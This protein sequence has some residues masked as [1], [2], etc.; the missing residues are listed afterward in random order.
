MANT[1]L[2]WHPGDVPKTAII[3]PFDL[4]EFLLMPL[5]LKNAAQDLQRLMDGILRNMSIMF[6]YL[7]SI[8]VASK[9]LKDHRNHLC[10]VFQ[11]LS[12]N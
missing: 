9:N 6:V 2:Q 12:T 11:L 8:L 5:G 1:R 3:T 4:W 7:D 10:Q